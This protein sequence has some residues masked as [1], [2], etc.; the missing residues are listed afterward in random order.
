MHLSAGWE[1]NQTMF[2]STKSNRALCVI[3]RRYFPC[4]TTTEKQTAETTFCDAEYFFW[5]VEDCAIMSN[6][7][8]YVCERPGDDVGEFNHICFH[9][10]CRIL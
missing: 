1:T 3:A 5:D 2:P 10:L 4:P 7:H 6:K 9:I 8:P